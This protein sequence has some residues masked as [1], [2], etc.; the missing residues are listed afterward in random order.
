MAMKN[1]RRRGNAVIEFAIGS[2]L[3]VDGT[4]VTNVEGGNEPDPQI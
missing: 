3:F 4:L 2:S 1:S